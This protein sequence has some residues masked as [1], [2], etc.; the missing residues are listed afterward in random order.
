MDD[1]KSHD[2]LNRFVGDLGAAMA[3]GGTVLA[4]PR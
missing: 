3:A 4:L 1:Q 2:F